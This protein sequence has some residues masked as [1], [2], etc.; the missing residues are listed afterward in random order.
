MSKNDIGILLTQIGSPTQPTPLAVYRYLRK[1]LSDPR[2]IELPKWLWLPL[3]HSIILP[4]RSKKT[5]SLYK[6]IW[7]PQGSPL[8]HLSQTVKKKLATNLQIPVVLGTHYGQ[9]SIPQALEELHDQKIKKLL[10][11]PLYP[12]YSATSTAAAF[13]QT[14]QVLRTW[15]CVPELRTIQHYATNEDYISAIAAS[16]VKH[17]EKAGLAQHLLFSFHSIP[18]RYVKA[19]DIYQEQCY[20]TARLIANKLNLSSQD[21]SISFQSRIGK[22]KWLSPYTDK[23]LQKLP[24]QGIEHVRV[25]CPGFSID[26]L[27]TLEEIS[28][29]GKEQFLSAG[30][31][32]FEY[33][34]ALNDESSYLEKIILR[35]IEGW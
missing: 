21:W 5:A 20:A 4:I 28:L 17:N 26:C 12:Q 31:K 18:E 35:N 8:I 24:K 23:T 1:F 10:L 32:K 14:T 3:L 7:L 29:R 16:I 33:I 2:V 13:D 27:E 11:F 19:G 22:T 6:K 30:G 9:P 34:P 15:R 25:I